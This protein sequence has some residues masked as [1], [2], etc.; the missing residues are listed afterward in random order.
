MLELQLVDVDNLR[1][2]HIHG[3]QNSVVAPLPK[4]SILLEA[5]T[6]EAAHPRSFEE[7]SV[8][9][10]YHPVSTTSRPVVLFATE[11]GI[12]LDYQI[13]DLFTGE[14][15]KPEYSAINPSHQVPVLE[16]GDFR[17]TES[18][19]ILKYLADKV[20][21]PAYPAD[22][23]KRA[24]VNERMDWLNTG[25]YRDFSYG[26]LYPQIFPFM[27]RPD[28]AVQAGTLAW[29]KEKALGWLKVLDEGLLGPR[30]AYLC[31]EEL[32]IADYLGSMMVLG[33][34]A[35][36]CKYASY[37]NV[38]RWLGNMKKLK[39]WEKVNEAFYKYVVD[40]NKGKEFV[41]L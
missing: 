14:Q 37:P 36:D 22:L 29:G 32:T 7:A 33:G 35:I 41:R 12:D 6:L 34:E 18:S 31:G 39:S 28:D 25:F 8:K 17:L 23:K 1:I 21:S 10:Y 16:D 24:R 30:S 15:Y 2:D 5:A 13:V 26:F 27:R 20:R 40:P 19:A 9:L 4:E 3:P 11:S 38:C